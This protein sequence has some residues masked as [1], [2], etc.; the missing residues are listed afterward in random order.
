MIE[1]HWEAQY[2][3]CI[4]S[5][6]GLVRGSNREAHSWEMHLRFHLGSLLKWYRLDNDLFWRQCNQSTDRW[7]VTTS[8]VGRHADQRTLFQTTLLVE[9]SM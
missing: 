7:I 3:V 6:F 2:Y 5:Q 8:I 4:R 1:L 9:L